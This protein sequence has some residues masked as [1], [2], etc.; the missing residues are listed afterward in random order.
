LGCAKKISIKNI[1]NFMKVLWIID[2]K[3]REL[4]GIYDIRKKLKKL[5]I[6]LVL[7]NKINWNLGVEYFNPDLIVFPNVR[8]GSP[9]K[10]AVDKAFKKNIK[11]V[12]YKSEG[13]HYEKEFME[14]EH[15]KDMLEKLTKIFLWADQEGTAAIKKGFKNKL[16]TIGGLRFVHKEKKIRNNKIIRIGIPTTNRYST[17]ILDKNLPRY[18]FTRTLKDKEMSIGLIKNEINFFV[19]ISEIFKRFKEKN[20]QFIIKPH[21]FEDIKIYKDAFSNIDKNILI[22]EDPDIR[23]FLN[24]IDVMLNQYSS[25]NIHAIKAGIPVLNLTKLIPWNEQFKIIRDQY[26]PK[27]YGIKVNSYD[28]LEKYLV[29]YTPKQI[30]DEIIKKGDLQSIEKICP[31]LDSVE[32]ASKEIAKI[33]SGTKKKKKNFFKK[34]LN[35]SKFYLKEIKIIIFDKRS[36][37]FHSIKKKDRDL[38][39]KFSVLE[40]N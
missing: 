40:N 21:P 24:K 14:R 38:L 33:L 13:L 36:T 26:L 15:P 8:D 6:D 31:T 10:S 12:L 18:I 37:L 23:N 9:F 29:R 4:W 25:S 28:D 2:N 20:F 27:D 7:C 16:I 35:F 5:S 22:E 11:C 3:L 34:I 32:L 1:N 17:N 39:K 30:Y 19:C